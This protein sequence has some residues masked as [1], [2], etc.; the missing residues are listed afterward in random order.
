MLLRASATL[1]AFVPVVGQAR[2]AAMLERAGYASA[3]TLAA[4]DFL[5]WGRP[6]EKPYPGCVAVF[7]RESPKSWQGHVGFYAGQTE[8]HILCLGGNQSDGVSI[9]RMPRSRV[10]GFRE[11]RPLATSGTVK[12]AVLAGLENR[13]WKGDA[14]RISERALCLIGLDPSYTTPLAERLYFDYRRWVTS[15]TEVA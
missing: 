4:R 6:V 11:P 2:Y 13:R 12:G 10:L 7:W 5:D 1:A 3:K 15:L 14:Q 9:T 8:T